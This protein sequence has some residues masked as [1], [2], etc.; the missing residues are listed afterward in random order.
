M[1]DQ[2]VILVDASGFVFRAYYSWTETY[3]E[4]G[5]PTWATLG[6]MA[7]VWRMLGAAQADKPTHGIAVF[8]PA[9][10]RNFRHDLC[11]EYKANRPQ[12]R[13]LELA[14]QFPYMR[15]A[16]ETLGLAT[17]EAAGFEA[18]D[19]IA[20]LAKKAVAAGIRVTIVSSDKDFAQLVVDDKIE[21]VDPM[22]KKRVRAADV[23]KK[24]GVPPRLV[25]TVQALA[26]DSIDN[27]KG[28][29]GVGL[30]K[31]AAL[32]RR[33]GDLEAI[34][35]NAD[36]C[37]WP[38]VRLQLQR[39][40]KEARLYL[41]LVT[42]RD[43][44]EC[45]V[46]WDELKLQPPLKSQINNLLTTLEAGP[47]YRLIFSGDYQLVRAFPKIAKADH[48]KWWREEL[49]FPGQT[50][51]ETPQCGFY[52]RR[53]VKGGPF[54]AGQ[55]WREKNSDDDTT[56]LLRCRVGGR[57]ADPVAEW[58]RLSQMPVAQK[59]HAFE[60]ADAEHARKYRPSDPKAQPRRKIDLLKAPIATNPKRKKK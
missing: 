20:T 43:D 34:L 46:V 57:D 24:F 31:A 30:E 35:K 7:L 52:Q 42:L 21:I 8:D 49:K 48:F 50:I 60:V 38:Q 47:A 53:L 4:D 45:H 54:V 1:T 41:Q 37:R 55:I 3:R 59:D 44:V 58:G 10:R 25:T 6:F 18:D 14:P 36:N 23:E 26:G 15:N 22:Q 29:P 5:L 13:D 17:Y 40:K 27:V 33:F 56:E 51:P 32:A 2:H 12:A 28:I 11:P 16:A 19:L 39:K 9:D